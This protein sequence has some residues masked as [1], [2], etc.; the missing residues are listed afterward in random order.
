MRMLSAG[1]KRGIL[2][3]ELTYVLLQFRY[4]SQQVANH[5]LNF[6]RLLNQPFF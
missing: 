6:R 3:R 5:H 4:L 2:G 1:W